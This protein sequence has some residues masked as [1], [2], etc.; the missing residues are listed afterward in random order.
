MAR[1]IDAQVQAFQ[2]EEA[3]EMT[4]HVRTMNYDLSDEEEMEEL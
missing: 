3:K 4:T 1:T 2:A